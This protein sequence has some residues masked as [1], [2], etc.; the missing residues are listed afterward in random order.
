[1]LENKPTSIFTTFLLSLVQRTGFHHQN[2]LWISGDQ[3][4]FTADMQQLH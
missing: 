2:R 1:M 3:A 4:L